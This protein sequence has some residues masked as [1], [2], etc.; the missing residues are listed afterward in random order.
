[1]PPVFNVRSQAKPQPSFKPTPLKEMMMV[2]QMEAKRDA[3]LQGAIPREL[4]IQPHEEHTAGKRMAR[5][6]EEGF[7]QEVSRVGQEAVRAMDEGNIDKVIPQIRELRRKKQRLMQ[8]GG[9]G[10]II[11]EYR[12]QAEE[13]LS[14][15]KKAYSD[16]PD[17]QEEKRRQMIEN[18]RR[19][20]PG[21][22]VVSEQ[23][24]ILAEPPD[25]ASPLQ[26]P[27]MF[28]PKDLQDTVDDYVKMEASQTRDLGY[29][30]K[31]MSQLKELKQE[32]KI[33]EKKYKDIV[34]NAVQRM[35]AD[36][37]LMDTVETLNQR[38]NRKIL[39]NLRL[40]A[41]N[42]PNYSIEQAQ[43]DFQK[44]KYDPESKFATIE[45]TEEGERNIRLNPNTLLG[46]QLSGAA[47][48]Q[49]FRRELMSYDIRTDEGALARYK[50]DLKDGE[51]TVSETASRVW[52][53]KDR[54]DKAKDRVSK[55]EDVLEMS[56]N[57]VHDTLENVT[58]PI[59]SKG[60]S[61][62]ENPMQMLKGSPLYEEYYQE[63]GNGATKQEASV[64]LAK[65]LENK[66]DRQQLQDYLLENHPQIADED[67]A[68]DR[69]RDIVGNLQ[70]V[71]TQHDQIQNSRNFV[72]AVEERI[73]DEGG[74]GNS[75]EEYWRQ[76]SN[77][78]S[79]DRKEDV[80]KAYDELKQ[81][82][83][84][85][86]GKEEA[87]ESI[88][89]Q[90]GPEVWSD[91][92]KMNRKE[93]KA[94]VPG[95]EQTVIEKGGAYDDLSVKFQGSTEKILEEE[96]K[97]TYTQIHPTG[98]GKTLVEDAKEVIKSGSTNLGLQF[99]DGSIQEFK[100]QR[101]IDN[102]FTNVDDLSV[103]L[104][105]SLGTPTAKIT[106]K[107]PEDE[108]FTQYI[109][110]SRTNIG[111]R[112]MNE[113]VDISTNVDP[114]A[115]RQ[116]KKSANVFVG[117]SQ[118]RDFRPGTIKATLDKGADKWNLQSEGGRDIG[119]VK[120]SDHGYY[121]ERPN[122]DR[123]TFGGNDTFESPNTI[124]EKMG[125]KLADRIG[126][127]RKLKDMIKAKQDYMQ[128]RAYRMQVLGMEP[129]GQR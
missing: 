2:P 86:I 117:A 97:E 124:V 44:V 20:D 5:Q 83:K 89:A 123:F 21:F 17:I 40:R 78:V 42:D 122:G 10:Q 19:H 1:M 41:Q 72:N 4:D 47:Q 85:G 94:I 64:N 128:E 6:L 106:G 84:E 87:K 26:S 15:V 31:S 121:L 34:S 48:Q 36:P 68:R 126:D 67:E 12:K 52:S 107:D 120:K 25:Q 101:G 60:S 116:S 109:D 91:L 99:S 108:E 110:M 61:M 81:M 95:G 82:V 103:E 8:P 16:R 93:S 35:R 13:R 37:N 23:G 88:S 71:K 45:E 74:Y 113:M 75:A 70:S 100:Q 80:R 27:G 28:E 9:R 62:K 79:G 111:N 39:E 30:V 55:A 14:N 58:R 96:R 118:I 24:E 129:R 90:Y 73:A 105:T 53:L 33:K 49:D 104:V 50:N 125:E 92:Q 51:F 77:V 114:D 63:I 29:N 38:E 66:E 57:R 69:V 54:Y 18:L 127:R 76:H 7:R 119:A 46:S 3:A 11:N 98:E 59:R 32:G 115:D 22:G 112:M 43:E 56:A 102:N 65:S